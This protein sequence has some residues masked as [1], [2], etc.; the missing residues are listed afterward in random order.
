MEIKPNKHK[1]EKINNNESELAQPIMSDKIIYGIS[2]LEKRKEE[3]IFDYNEFSK[4]VFCD[5]DCCDCKGCGEEKQEETKEE[6]SCCDSNCCSNEE[7]EKTVAEALMLIINKINSL[8]KKI[9]DK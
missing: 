9:F 5:S 1:R 4:E 7:F 8:E 6:K 3:S 2:N